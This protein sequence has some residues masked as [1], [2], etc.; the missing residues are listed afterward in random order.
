[1]CETTPPVAQT[2]MRKGIPMSENK[3]AHLK[4]ERIRREALCRLRDKYRDEYDR[5][6]E[7]MRP[8]VDTPRHLSQKVLNAMRAEHLD[9]FAQLREQIR[10]ERNWARL[11]PA[12]Q[13]SRKPVSLVKKP[14]DDWF[15]DEMDVWILYDRHLSLADIAARLRQKTSVIIDVLL[16]NLLTQHGATEL[17][18]A[19]RLGCDTQIIWR[20]KRRLGLIDAPAA[21]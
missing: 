20:S 5:I 18:I 8:M 13:F 1:M 6:F 14:R 17:D 21:A 4:N 9:E 19:Q 16:P 3:Q 15:L 2:V 7:Q 11:P 12:G 10:L